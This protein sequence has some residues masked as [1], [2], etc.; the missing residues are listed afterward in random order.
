[1]PAFV[2]THNESIKLVGLVTIHFQDS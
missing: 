2:K 1:M